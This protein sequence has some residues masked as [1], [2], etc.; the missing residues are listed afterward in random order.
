[1]E[2]FIVIE[3]I[4]GEVSVQPFIEREMALHYVE[5][6][7]LIGANI[8]VERHIMNVGWQETISC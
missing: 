8:R 2:V 5:M 1:M 6:E 4:D 7:S 3:Q